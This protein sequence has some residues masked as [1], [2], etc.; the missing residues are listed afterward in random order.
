M[1]S[2]SPPCSASRC[3]RLPRPAPRAPARARAPCRRPSAALRRPAVPGTAS[4]R[5]AKRKPPASSHADQP[6][7]PAAAT[8]A[9]TGAR[10]ARP[11]TRW[12]R[13]RSGAAGRPRPAR[14]AS[15]AGRPSSVGLP[16]AQERGWSRPDGARPRSRKL[17]HHARGAQRVG[18][19]R[20]AAR[21]ELDQQRP[22][23]GRPRS[24]QCWT[25]ARPDQLAEQLADL[26]RGD[27]VPGGA[28]RIAARCSSRAAGWARAKRHVA[29]RRRDRAVLADQ[30][31]QAGPRAALNVPA[32][33]PGAGARDDQEEPEQRASAGTG[34]GPW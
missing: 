11:G 3:G 31:A 33:R 22:R 24:S 6:L 18:H 1:S 25:R 26:G 32:P 9:R 2:A 34:A 27:E 5:A 16:L 20:A 15:A 4:A 8:G 13:R 30:P 7:V 10:A 29:A 12:R 14:R 23:P 17:G 28:Q 21:A 19:Q